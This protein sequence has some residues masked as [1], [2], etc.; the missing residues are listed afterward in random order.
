MPASRGARPHRA[1]R[2]ADRQRAAAR[3]EPASSPNACW[4]SRP[5]PTTLAGQPFNLGSPKQI[6]EI[7]FGKLGMPV[8]RKTA[9]GAPSTDEDVLQQLAA[10]YPLPARLLE[11]R[12]LSKLKG[13]YT[14]KLP[15]MVNPRD[16]PRAHQL[17][18]G[19][20]G[21]RAAV[22]Q[23]AEPAEHPDP[24]RRGPARARGLH[25]AAGPLDPLGR[26]LADRAAHHGA[27]LRGRRAAAR[28]RAKAS[29]CTARPP[30]RSSAPRSTRSAA[31]S[32]ATPRSSTSA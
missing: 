10:D 20:R 19:G 6:G 17:C 15:L 5:R 8:L 21:D 11:H 7:L 28:V 23:R 32:G 29:T 18:A 13:T 26:L 31:S 12:S 27:H 14:D 24:H 2:R 16:R 4:R 1:Q 30:A 9:S 22:E 3:A 25:R